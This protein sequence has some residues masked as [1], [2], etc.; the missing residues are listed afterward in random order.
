MD[1]VVSGEIVAQLA[2]LRFQGAFSASQ[3]RIRLA[4]M[5]YAGLALRNPALMGKMAEDADN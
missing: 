4:A 1:A 5:M 3:G 2:H